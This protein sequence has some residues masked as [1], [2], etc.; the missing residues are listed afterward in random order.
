MKRKALKV[1]SWVVL[2]V[3]IA[4][5]G[6][7][8]NLYS[9][10]DEVT[11]GK[12]FDEEI[13]NNPDEYPIYHG[14]PAVKQYISDNIFREILNAQ[15]VQ[16]ESTYNYEIEILDDDATMNAFAVPGGYVFVYTGLIKY[17]GSEAAL[18]GVIAHEIAH[19]ERRH[20]TQQMTNQYG[21]QILASMALG[22]NPSQ[23]STI[24]ANLVSGMTILANSRDAEDE[25][26][27]YAIKYLAGTKYYPGGVKFFFERM[28][29]DG[30]VEESAGFETFFSTHP[31]PIDRIN[32]AN[33]R[34]E[35]R[36]EPIYNYDDYG[37]E[38][39][40]RDSYVTNVLNRI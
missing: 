38:G 20:S 9:R 17:L 10:Q 4:A 5:C 40:Y 16:Y 34:L 3:V 35:Q 39:I 13:H 28:K 1:Y 14:N 8:I 2:I 36:G 33:E 15:E 26:D 30:K 19:V 21:L 18:A 12:Q 27:E 22:E 31:D 7:G 6:T 23:V 29:A 24:V 25:A 32:T 37:K 11:L